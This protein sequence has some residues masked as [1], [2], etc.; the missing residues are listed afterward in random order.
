MKK[1]LKFDL[2]LLLGNSPM[3]LNLNKLENAYEEFISIIYEKLR[4][5]DNPFKLYY[6]LGVI[7]LE[8]LEMQSNYSDGE[9]KNALKYITKAISIIDMSLNLIKWQ[10]SYEPKILFSDKKK[11][12]TSL[13]WARDISDLVLLIYGLAD[14][15][16]FNNGEVN[17]KEISDCIG[18]IFGI[19]IKDCSNIFR[20]IRKR[21]IKDR[22]A[23]L[24]E[25]K[26]RILLRMDN[27]DNGIYT[28]SK[29]RRK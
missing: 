28:Y 4:E 6:E 2:F 26:E 9:E 17:I 3:S 29:G 8:L 13:K 23:F 5:R 14:M 10:M 1:L 22:T 24:D 21:K 16:S 15:S 18:K 20:Q 7:R 11:P 25:M 19:E 12:I 27:A